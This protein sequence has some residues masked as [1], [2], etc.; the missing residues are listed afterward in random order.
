VS[1]TGKLNL[2]LIAFS[3]F[4][5]NCALLA[6]FSIPPETPT[7]VRPTFTRAPIPSPTASPIVSP[8]SSA[9]PTNVSVAKILPSPQPARATSTPTSRIVAT[10]T[11]I[12]TT[13]GNSSSA[14]TK[15]GPSAL[16]SLL[17]NPQ[18][19]LAS[20]TTFFTSV[21]FGADANLLQEED[22]IDGSDWATSRR[23][24][25]IFGYAMNPLTRMPASF[26]KTDTD[27]DGHKRFYL[28]P[29]EAFASDPFS[30]KQLSQAQLIVSPEYGCV[31][32]GDIGVTADGVNYQCE[33]CSFL[34][35]GGVCPVPGGYKSLVLPTNR[36]N[37]L[38]PDANGGA[39]GF[40][41][42]PAIIFKRDL[43]LYFTGKDGYAPP[44]I[45]FE[46]AVDT[47]LPTVNVKTTAEMSDQEIR[48]VASQFDYF[49][50][51]ADPKGLLATME[52]EARPTGSF[53]VQLNP[54]QAATLIFTA[55]PGTV[56]SSVYWRIKPIGNVLN[57]QYLETN[58]C[59]TV[60]GRE[61]CFT[62]V[63]DFAHCAFF[64]ACTTGYSTLKSVGEQGYIATRY[65]PAGTAPW[66]N[67]GRVTIRVQAPDIGIP[68]EMDFKVRVRDV[69]AALGK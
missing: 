33:A 56:L 19:A 47:L 45:Y 43:S 42:Y 18:A 53:P 61:A 48:D 26:Y 34:K 17:V 10:A 46:N 50:S 63:E 22:H 29:P 11:P 24:D 16:V 2:A 52:T 68:I 64:Q 44:R 65:F 67:D 32:L 37:I 66:I 21:C 35:A 31:S 13:Q 1:K 40:L 39:H 54:R 8:I 49:L 6:P 14:P 15:L 55:R 12:P 58:V 4:I 9:P 27:T 51:P 23:H 36:N 41:A 3:I 62:G 28:I 25:C 57:R 60:N 59:L 38:D 7:T 20:R 30:I 69:D 5:V